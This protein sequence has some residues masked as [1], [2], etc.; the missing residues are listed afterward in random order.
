MTGND[1]EDTVDGTEETADEEFD[2]A[3][4]LHEHLRATEELPVERE[5]GW[6]IGE[7][8]GLAAQVASGDLDDAVVR[9][10]AAEIRELLAEIDRTGDREADDRVEAARELAGRLAER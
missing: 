7:A 9:E 1:R 3:R 10:R 4:A 6:R 2:P 5:A 8:Q